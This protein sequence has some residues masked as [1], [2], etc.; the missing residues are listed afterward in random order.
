M[1]WMNLIKKYF[2]GL[3][4][5]SEKRDDALQFTVMGWGGEREV[6]PTECLNSSTTLIK[7]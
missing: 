7:H 3:D 5:D 2:L 4:Y 6:L 1:F